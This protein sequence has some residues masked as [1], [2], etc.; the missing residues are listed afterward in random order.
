MPQKKE[1]AC[2]K[3]GVDGKKMSPLKYIEELIMAGGIREK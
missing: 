3:A 2:A 1:S